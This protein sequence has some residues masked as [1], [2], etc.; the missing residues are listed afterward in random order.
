[1]KPNQKVEKQYIKLIRKM[2]GE[3]RLKASFDLYEFAREIAI[4]G[5]KN[6]FPNISQSELNKKLHERIPK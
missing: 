1:M 6:Q 3:E 2:S 5:I 4:A